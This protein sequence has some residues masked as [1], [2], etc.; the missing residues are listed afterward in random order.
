M[1]TRIRR[2]GWYQ[3]FGGGARQQS[4]NSSVGQAAGS[5]C[6]VPADASATARQR[7]GSPLRTC[8]PG[9]TKT[10]V[11]RR[12]ENP[13]PIWGWLDDGMWERVA[14]YRIRWAGG[15]FDCRGLFNH[16]EMAEN[17]EH[18]CSGACYSFFFLP[19]STASGRQ[20]MM[21]WLLRAVERVLSLGGDCHSTMPVDAGR[22]HEAREGGLRASRRLGSKLEAAQGAW[23]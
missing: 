5:A 18:Q 15:H 6:S 22:R 19:R 2:S 10:V 16:R 17:K 7:P 13:S 21:N 3:G 1:A 11:A 8:S 12:V 4:S 23:D 14:Y 20:G 9:T